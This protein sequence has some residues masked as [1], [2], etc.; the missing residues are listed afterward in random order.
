MK[1]KSLLLFGGSA[2]L[3]ALFFWTPAVSKG[4]NNT[5]FPPGPREEARLDYPL[6]RD[7]VVT[8]DPRAS[9]KPVIAG[10]ANK[11][12]GFV[13]PDTAEGILIHMDSDWLVLRDGSEENWIPQ[14]KVLMIR[15]RR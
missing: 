6:N 15:V 11:V 10:E 9:S 13:A 2:T 4:I 14:S 5:D 1:Q 7:C 3:A 12:S 8:V